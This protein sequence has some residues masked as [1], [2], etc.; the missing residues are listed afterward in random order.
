MTI[1]FLQFIIK[2]IE[3]NSLYSGE[4][5]NHSPIGNRPPP[6]VNPPSIPRESKSFEGPYVG[7]Y[8]QRN[9]IYHLFHR[10]AASTEL[11]GKL[12]TISRQSLTPNS[13]EAQR[14]A[15][16]INASKWFLNNVLGKQGKLFKNERK[17]FTE[18]LL[19]ARLQ[20]PVDAFKN[21]PGLQQ[22]IE[23]NHFTRPICDIYKH[24]ITY[25]ETTHDVQILMNN[26]MTSWAVIKEAIK[27]DKNGKAQGWSY[28]Y[29]GLIQHNEDK[30]DKL[31][32]YMILPEGERPKEYQMEIVTDC[33][34]DN[35]DDKGLEFEDHSWI[36]LKTPAGEVYSFGLYPED[37]LTKSKRNFLATTKG[38]LKCP[39]P[40][41]YLPQVL[42]S[43][44][45]VN[46]DENFFN[47]IKNMV[48]NDKLKDS[49]EYNIFTYNCTD[50]ALALFTPCSEESSLKN[51][52]ERVSFK[53]LMPGKAKAFTA[54]VSK[55]LMGFL[56]KGKRIGSA[57]Q[58]ADSTRSKS[59][60]TIPTLAHPRALRKW[61]LNPDGNLTASPK[62]SKSAPA[63]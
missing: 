38:M 15:E 43:T 26:K 7:S 2:N 10:K 51:L 61:I 41:E 39:D 14:A 31:R 27:P 9:K 50:F 58:K 18:A 11:L 36:R 60:E 54:I 63:A 16:T 20:I 12:H 40:N 34:R 45:T 1:N 44:K 19:A 23:K 17:Q 21:N 46:I 24:Q 52:K 49:L 8:T 3:D 56:G 59:E 62:T 22:F 32:P 53:E 57:T 28:N 13:P 6:P 55:F 37:I 29:E 48:E 5:M 42:L 30:W 4:I 25:D 47:Q 33:Y 35:L